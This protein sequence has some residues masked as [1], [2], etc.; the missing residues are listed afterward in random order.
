MVYGIY[1]L[2][3]YL[4]SWRDSVAEATGKKEDEFA[5]KVSSLEKQYDHYRDMK[6]KS[7][8]SKRTKG[9]LNVHDLSSDRTKSELRAKTASERSGAGKKPSGATSEGGKSS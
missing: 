4:I 6:T 8:G 3:V 7:G 9:A 5:Q 2:R 1:K